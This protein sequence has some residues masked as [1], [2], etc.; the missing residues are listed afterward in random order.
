M[1]GQDA[2]AIGDSLLEFLGTVDEDMTATDGSEAHVQHDMQA[3]CM[4]VCG[5]QVCG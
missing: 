3:R 5:C 1:M 2:G 4:N